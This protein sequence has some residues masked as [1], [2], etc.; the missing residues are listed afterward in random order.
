[1]DLIEFGC[2]ELFFAERE[3]L[4]FTAYREEC[5]LAQPFKGYK[6]EQIFAD[7]PDWRV[8][9]DTL[10]CWRHGSLFSTLD[11][12]TTGISKADIATLFA[13]KSDGDAPSNAYGTW[14]GRLRPAR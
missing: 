2:E 13:W 7:H 12:A 6:Q 14:S 4:G 11:H 3:M 1:M 9:R 8:H 10:G 5:G